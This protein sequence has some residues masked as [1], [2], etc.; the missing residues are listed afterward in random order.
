MMKHRNTLLRNKGEDLYAMIITEKF[1]IPISTLK[2][3][4]LENG[5]DVSPDLK[6]VK[7]EYRNVNGLDLLL[8][9]MDGTIQGIKFSYYGY[10]YSN[11]SGTVQF[12]TYTSQNLLAEYK[13]DIEDLLNGLVVIDGSTE[14]QS[15]S[16][17]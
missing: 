17:S 6:I 11:E 5:R 8:M 13:S 12:L 4:A 15:R 2:D 10:Y 3:V 16:W 14:K 7:E 1:E 9:Q